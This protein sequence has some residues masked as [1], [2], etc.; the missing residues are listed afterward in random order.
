[1]GISRD[2]YLVDPKGEIIKTYESVDPKTHIND[3]V[4]DFRAIA[5]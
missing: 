4:D 1:M 5:S 2:S 3:I